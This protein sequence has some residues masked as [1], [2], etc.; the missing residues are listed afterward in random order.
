MSFDREV[1]FVECHY[2]HYGVGVVI[3]IVVRGCAGLSP[4]TGN[5]SSYA[6]CAI[7]LIKPP[8][9]CSMSMKC[10]RALRIFDKV[11]ADAESEVSVAFCD[12]VWEDAE[13]HADISLRWTRLS[14]GSRGST[15][16]VTKVANMCWCRRAPPWCRC[17]AWRCRRMQRKPCF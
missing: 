4:G 16:M 11:A 2:C 3:T 5:W 14:H 1:G 6:D 10:W 9:S 7:H 13:V 17:S 15:L 8:W 12:R